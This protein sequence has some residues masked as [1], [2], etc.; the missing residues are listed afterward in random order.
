MEDPKTA[1]QIV[2]ECIQKFGRIDVLVNTDYTVSK[3][4]KNCRIRSTMPVPGRSR[5]CPTPIHWRIWTF[6]TMSTCA[7]ESAWITSQQFQFSVILLTKLALP[8]LERTKGNVISLSSCLAI[9]QALANYYSMLKAAL[10]HWTRYMA[11]TYAPKGV[12]FNCIKWGKSGKL[13]NLW[14]FSPGGTATPIF[15]RNG[16]KGE[17]ADLVRE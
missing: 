13:F 2:A 6:S 11:Q 17:V 8:H 1:E 4:T 16:F 9:R 3:I 14:I 10:D 5:T 15:E 7:G 12:R